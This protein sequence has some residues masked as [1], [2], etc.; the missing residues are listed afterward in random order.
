MKRVCKLCVSPTKRKALSPPAGDNTA[1]KHHDNK[2]KGKGK[3]RPNISTEKAASYKPCGAD[4][5]K[6]SSFAE[7]SGDEDNDGF[8][9]GDSASGT[10]RKGTA[11]SVFSIPPLWYSQVVDEFATLE[12]TAEECSMNGVLYHLRKAKLAWLSAIGAR[13]IKQQDIR[14]FFGSRN[15]F[16]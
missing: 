14:D 1:S 6:L 10:V 12:T 2:D 15:F 4:N 7:S 9:G 3:V 8:M 5:R 11:S 16:Y 13:S